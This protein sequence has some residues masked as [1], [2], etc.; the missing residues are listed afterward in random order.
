M[1]M[2]QI[3]RD[4]QQQSAHR[5]RVEEQITAYVIEE[6]I[7]TGVSEHPEGS[8]GDVFQALEAVRDAVEREILSG[9]RQS[10]RANGLVQVLAEKILDNASRARRKIGIPHNV[11]L[12][13]VC[14][15]VES[16]A[17]YL[18][19]RSTD[20]KGYIRSVKIDVPP[21]S[22][23]SFLNRLTASVRAG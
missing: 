19:E 2:E 10:P 1:E 20:G 6:A 18:S 13:R 14:R 15:L 3:E 8:D 7:S 11:L 16:R 12:A 23:D 22:L 21:G 5:A 17:R 9:V 4:W